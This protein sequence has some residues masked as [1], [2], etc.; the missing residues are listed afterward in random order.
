M[1]TDSPLLRSSIYACVT[2]PY[3]GTR[4]RARYRNAQASGRSSGLKAAPCAWRS[5]TRRMRAT[6]ARTFVGDITNSRNIYGSYSHNPARHRPFI[7]PRPGGHFQIQTHRFKSSEITMKQK[8]ILRFILIEYGVP[9]NFSWSI[10]L[11]SQNMFPNSA[12]IFEIY[13][14][15]ERILCPRLSEI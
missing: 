4:A 5:S 1:A 7:R 3:P 8:N 2:G 11:G 14:Q 13:F 10:L 6:G 15:E 12:H 9:K